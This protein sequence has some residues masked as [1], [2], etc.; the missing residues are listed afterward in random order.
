VPAQL[1]VSMWLVLN[2]VCAGRP[3]GKTCRSPLC[4]FWG[5][6]TPLVA[7]S[8]RPPSSANLL[9]VAARTSTGGLVRFS[10]SGVAR[11]D[12]VALLSVLALVFASAHAQLEGSYPPA[13]D[14][15]ATVPHQVTLTFGEPVEVAAGAVQV[16]DDHFTRADDDLV[17]PADPQRNRIR[18]GLNDELAPGTYTVSWKVSS[19]GTHQAS[20]SFHFSIGAPG[21]VSGAVAGRTGV[22]RPERS[23]DCCAAWATAAWCAAPACCWWCLRCGPP[24]SVIGSRGVCCG[25][26]WGCWVSARSA[27]WCCRA[28]GRAACR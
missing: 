8:A 24:V 20:S 16:F 22:T 6:A 9:D 17:E 2:Q 11:T 19:A 25:P 12:L 10:R 5:V 27:G 21:E 28:F 18:A 15:L 14:V 1:P 13:G 26:D 3:K 7:A 23:W 4:F